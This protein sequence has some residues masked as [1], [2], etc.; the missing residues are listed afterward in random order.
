MEKNNE[1]K[2]KFPINQKAFSKL[3]KD[4]TY[5]IGFLWGDGYINKNRLQLALSKKDISHLKKF[6]LFLSSL[7]RPIRIF[8]VK[9][10]DN[11][12]AE[13][14]VRSWDIK[15]DLEKYKITIKKEIRGKI[16]EEILSK[17]LRRDFIRGLFDADGCFYI[18]NRGYLFSEITGKYETIEDIQK[19]LIE[20]KILDKDSKIYKNGSIFRLR[21]CYSSTLKFGLYIY[22][23]KNYYLDRK[24]NLFVE[25]LNKTLQKNENRQ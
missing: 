19:V 18:D 25:Y 7:T 8:K 1:I 4:S 15:E 17:K 21:L 24:Y 10:S 11:E 20:E 22:N 23:N 12:Y 5:W 3:T 2:R 9:G 14:R 13:V 16:P 6:N